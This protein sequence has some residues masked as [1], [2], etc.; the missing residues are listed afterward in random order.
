MTTARFSVVP[1]QRIEIVVRWTVDPEGVDR[2][3]LQLPDGFV[4]LTAPDARRVASLL[5]DTA[6]LQGKP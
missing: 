2:I 5:L 4:L 3:L 6:D 1:G